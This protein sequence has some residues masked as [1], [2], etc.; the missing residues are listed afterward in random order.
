[1]S[2]FI[3]SGDN[4]E[5]IKPLVQFSA[6]FELLSTEEEYKIITE[7]YVIKQRLLPLLIKNKSINNTMILLVLRK[8]ALENLVVNSNLKLV[9]FNA[10]KQA[11]IGRGLTLYD[12]TL[13]GLDG[14]IYCL[15]HKNDPFRNNKFSTY[16]TTWIKQRIGKAIDKYGS[17]VKTSGHIKD[18]QSKIRMVV[19]EF[20]S[21]PKNQGNKPT[22][23]TISLLLYIKYNGL[24]ISAEK[25]AELGRLQWSHLS[26]DE[27]TEDN[28]MS[29]MDY[30]A[31]G[32]NYNP[33]LTSE[34]SEMLEK[35]KHY[36]ST[37]E[38]NEALII[39]YKYGLIDSI[40]RSGKE[41]CSL[42]GISP[43]ELKI[44]E[45]RAMEQL[46]LVMPKDF[47]DMLF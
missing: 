11:Y 37:L 35:V 30:I 20:C 2:N 23:E 45:A 9:F 36:V 42:L 5:E 12:R 15:R 14:L 18:L 31:A 4:P 10:R 29:L 22:A 8:I 25:V 39:S 1:M 17:I 40:S 7:Y 21:D 13:A 28:T 44:T 27:T 38:T 46:R 47:L 3:E 43:K 16:A 6:N 41:I 33:E 26:L 32:D 24:D 19:R 34:K